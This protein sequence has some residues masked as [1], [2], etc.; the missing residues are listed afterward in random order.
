MRTGASIT[1]TGAQDFTS[2][3]DY[4][5]VAEDSS[6]KTYTVTV[7]IGTAPLTTHLVSK[8]F[9][10]WTGSGTANPNP[11]AAT[12]SPPTGGGTLLLLPI[13]LA[14]GTLGIIFLAAW[15]TRRQRQSR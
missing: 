3:V 10:T 4:T 1:P 13:L 14:A 9:G 11:G 15:R 7:M 12:T 6:S 8:H 2:T 5:V